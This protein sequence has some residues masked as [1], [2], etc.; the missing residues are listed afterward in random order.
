MALLLLGKTICP[1][2]GLVIRDGQELKCF[3]PFVSNELDSLII[4]NDACFHLNCFERHELADEALE[5]SE[6]ALLQLDTNTCVL[7]GKAL[8]DYDDYFVM[9]GF[10]GDDASP[11]YEFNYLK[12]HRSCLSKWDRRAELLRLVRELKDSGSWRGY[13]V[14]YLMRELE[15]L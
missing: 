3:P 10:S 2:C 13:T 4:F 12:M 5:R 15:I 11:L 8:V 14:D 7:C 9:P 6:E 1:I